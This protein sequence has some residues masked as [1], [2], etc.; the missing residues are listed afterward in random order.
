MT[1]K[2]KP[3]SIYKEVTDSIIA[4]LEEGCVPWV[5]PWGSAEGAPAAGLPKNVISGKAYSGINILN[6][7]GSLFKHEFGCQ[8]WLTYK[9]AKELGGNVRK[10]EQGTMVCY[11][12]SFIPKDEKEK[13]LG[14]GEEPRR[15][16]F[17]KR[18]TVFNVEQCEGLPEKAYEGA[19]PLPECE[20]VPMAEKLIAA[21][22]ADF[23]IG[24]NRAFY[25]PAE[26]Y[27]QVPPQPAFFQQIDYY[28]T[29]FH[30]LGHWTG[31]RSRFDRDLP[32]RFGS[33]GY[34]REELV[35]ELASAFVCAALTI[36]PTVRHADYIGSWLQVLKEDDIAI[37]KAA[38]QASKAADYVLGCYRETV[39][40][41]AA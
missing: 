37:F 19:T 28:R 1:R 14:D 25:R 2:H 11:A 40:Q 36:K 34:A 18:Y 12:D 3:A 26:D 38:S 27:I 32:N 4:Q 15:V 31:H 30:E 8:N 17:L 7:W 35:A 33:K 41:E 9:Q 13:L 10:G 22:G 5:Q 20:Q 6:L 29:C 23:R 24:G 16:A 39:E 21:S